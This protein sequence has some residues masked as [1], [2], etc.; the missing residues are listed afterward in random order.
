MIK[1]HVSRM[2]IFFT[3]LAG[4]LYTLYCNADFRMIIP[5]LPALV[6]MRL[7]CDEALKARTEG[8]LD[9]DCIL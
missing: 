5:V 8:S 7:T 2:I 4:E 9:T 3:P 6:F 1:Y